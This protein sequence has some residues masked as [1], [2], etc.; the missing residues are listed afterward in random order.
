MS[1]KILEQA[2]TD[3]PTIRPPRFSWR[4]PGG[5]TGTLRVPTICCAP[6]HELPEEDEVVDLALV[7]A[8]FATGGIELAGDECYG[9]APRRR[10]TGLSA[11]CWPRP[12]FFVRDLAFPAKLVVR[13]RMIGPGE[14][15]A[16]LGR[17]LSAEER[18]LVVNPL[19]ITPEITAE[20]R[21]LT[22]GLTNKW[23]RASPSSLKSRGAGAALATAGS[24][25]PARR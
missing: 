16:E 4:L 17:R 10:R 14:L 22:L 21:R 18:K 13:P 6:L 20:A 3:R 11:T 19:E 2:H 9:S 7:N 12:P 8:A 23:L 5:R 25:R 1:T 15:N 24:G